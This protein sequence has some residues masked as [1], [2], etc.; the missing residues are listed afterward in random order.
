MGSLH[1]ATKG[2]SWE[3]HSPICLLDQNSV[4]PTANNTLNH[5]G[6]EV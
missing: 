3:G 4:D 5:G 1:I 6:G 2:V